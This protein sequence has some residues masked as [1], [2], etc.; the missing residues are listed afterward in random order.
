[1]PTSLTVLVVSGEE[2]G[3]GVVAMLAPTRTTSTAKTT[4]T[5]LRLLSREKDARGPNGRDHGIVQHWTVLNNHQTSTWPRTCV[6]YF[7]AVEFQTTRI[8]T[9]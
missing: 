4:K 9:D 3:I 1:M 2:I 5:V 6:T 8:R 7:N